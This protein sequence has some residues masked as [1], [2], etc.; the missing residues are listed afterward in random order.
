MTDSTF[1]GATPSPSTRSPAEL[2]ARLTEDL[3][4]AAARGEF[5]AHFQPQL[6]LATGRIVAAEALCR[7][8]H[9]SIGF[10]APSLF[11]GLAEQSSVIHEVGEFMLDES[12]V[13]LQKTNDL[14]LS[15]DVAVNVSPSQ[16]TSSRV[17]ER[18]A[19]QIEAA[20]LDPGRLTLEITESVEI[21]DLELMAA[22]LHAL[23]VL[24]VGISIDDFGA[25]H[26]STGQL[27]RLPVT[28]VK[29]DRSLIQGRSAPQRD[30]LQLVMALARE[31]DLRVIAEGV[32]N[33]EQKQYAISVG[34]HRAQGYLM[35]K[36]MPFSWFESYLSLQGDPR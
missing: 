21:T 12:T 36:A 7:W 32:E 28:E 13:F 5:V 1:V 27:T 17:V 25:G 11:I 23:R 29:I 19:P 10:V 6:D 9:P 30:Q 26:S 18:L 3:I 8:R 24:G 31:R 22:R 15:L 20:S 34:C 4:G 14:G 16:L 2:R 35:G 33:L